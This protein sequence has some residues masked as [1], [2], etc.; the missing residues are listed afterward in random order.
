MWCLDAK[1]NCIVVELLMIK[2]DVFGSLFVKKKQDNG[3]KG[4]IGWREKARK[5]DGG[6]K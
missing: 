2:D 3:G 6:I 4:R 1:A 5:V